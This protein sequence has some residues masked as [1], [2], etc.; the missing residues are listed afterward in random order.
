MEKLDEE[1]N[2]KESADSHSAEPQVETVT[3]AMDQMSLESTATGDTDT[4]DKVKGKEDEDEEEEGDEI[5]FTDKDVL[6]NIVDLSKDY[7]PQQRGVTSKKEF[8][9]SD[10]IQS[11][12]ALIWVTY[13]VLDQSA[14]ADAA[15]NNKTPATP[16]PKTEKL[17]AFFMQDGKNKFH[18]LPTPLEEVSGGLLIALTTLM[19]LHEESKCDLMISDSEWALFGSWDPKYVPAAEAYTWARK[20][21]GEQFSQ[22]QTDKWTMERFGLMYAVV[23]TNA[24]IAYSPISVH[25]YGAGMFPG[26]AFFN[27]SCKPNAIAVVRPGKLVIQA[28]DHIKEGEE[29]TIAYKE[30]PVDLLSISMVRVIHRTLGLGELGCKCTMCQQVEQQ[31][32]AEIEAAGGDP[33]KDE[34]IMEGQLERVWTE[35]TSARLQ[36]DDQLMAYVNSLI[37]GPLDRLGAAAAHALR[38]RYAHFLLYDANDPDHGRT[39]KSYCADLAFVLSDIYC[40]TTIHIRGQN[41]D[42]YLWWADVFLRSILCSSVNMPKTLT[43]AYLA[44]CYASIMACQHRKETEREAYMSDISSFLGNWVSL[45][46]LHK[47]IFA[48]TAY[49]MLPCKAYAVFG[50][51]CI[52]LAPQIREMERDLAQADLAE[53][54]TNVPE[55]GDEDNDIQEREHN[56]NEDQTVVTE[57]T[58]TQEIGEEA[59]S[60][61]VAAVMKEEEVTN[62]IHELSIK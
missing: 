58:T 22:E 41:P 6:I 62:G 23:Q 2:V 20:L 3:D 25:A 55:E 17:N 56:N 21:Y 5:H 10:A 7:G 33:E 43:Q 50:E 38:D 24:F 47:T 32:A 42:V 49:L 9:M 34:R 29:I 45:R 46:A 36:L 1:V 61:P 26:A 57:T 12:V 53:V 35:E 18:V 59:K 31:E 15:E 30:L 14:A 39:N 4:M 16:P 44:K 48:T 27:H 40:S 54:E 11:E 52:K 8:N 28:V 37:K 13:K 19:I 51:L 60:D